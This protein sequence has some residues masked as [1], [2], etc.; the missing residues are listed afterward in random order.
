MLDLLVAPLGEEERVCGSS[1][2][3]AD[4]CRPVISFGGCGMLYPYQLGC[5]E[6]LTQAFDCGG[7]RAAGH[8]A[9]FAAALSLA[10]P[11]VTADH[12]W[13]VLLS[14]RERWKSRALGFCFDSEAA[15]MAPYVAALAPLEA[16]VLAAA[17]AG[18]LSLGHTR[19][20]LHV[21]RWPPVTAGHAVS[22][23]F[24]S[25]ADFVHCVTVSQR[26]PPFYR[27]PGWR[28]G[29]W[30]LDGA[31]SA[32][33]TLPPGVVA[34]GGVITVSPTNGGATVRPNPPLPLAWFFSLPTAERWAALRR[35]GF[36]D[37]AAARDVLLAAGL[38][39]KPGAVPHFC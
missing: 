7:V 4:D 27:A 5:V 6:Y 21:A 14:A 22:S 24:A 16:E 17:N 29:A 15:W 11:G 37:A 35:R 20:R 30:G 25:L 10:C 31:L 32:S 1:P 23:R 38:V 39:P 34:G 3:G 9:G 18:R 13:R 2:A 28:A 33:F 12:H 36:D 8:S 19:L 26:T